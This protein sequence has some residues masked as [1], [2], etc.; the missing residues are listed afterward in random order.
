MTPILPATAPGNQCSLHR[1]H[2][3]ARPL[4]TVLH[5]VWPLG[6]GGPNTA[7]NK[8]ATCDNGH[9]AVHELLTWL[10]RNI[11]TSVL[12]SAP[13]LMNRDRYDTA[14]LTRT[15]RRQTQYRTASRSERRIAVRGYLDWHQ[16]GRPDGP[17][18]L[19]LVANAE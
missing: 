7:A 9:Y 3:S 8:V 17:S 12:S 2:G 13:G 6:M 4:R 16:A 15:L 14:Y 18:P 10:V 5:H 11:P 19:D 1:T